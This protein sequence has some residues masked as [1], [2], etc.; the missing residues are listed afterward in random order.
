MGCTPLIPA[1]LPAAALSAAMRAVVL[2]GLVAAADA[3]C[4]M[5]WSPSCL[6]CQAGVSV[7]E[8]CAQNPSMMGCDQYASSAVSPPPPPPPSP[9]ACG[10][11]HAGQSSCQQYSAST[12]QWSSDS[13]CCACQG[14]G[15]CQA[16]FQYAAGLTNGEKVLANAAGAL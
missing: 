2:L 4:C 6:A 8:Y 1:P 10:Q 15:G 13:S 11:A 12:G 16:G 9:L 3:Q 14:D 7:E 5:A